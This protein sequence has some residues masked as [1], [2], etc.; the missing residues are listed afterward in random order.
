MESSSTLDSNKRRRL[1]PCLQSDDLSAS[2]PSLTGASAAAAPAAAAA[3]SAAA[4]A[5]ASAASAAAAAASAAA[6]PS[7]TGACDETS[8]ETDKDEE[9]PH[10]AHRG[11][12]SST[13]A[14]AHE[15]V[16]AA[17]M[18]GAIPLTN[19]EAV[20]LTPKDQQR[21][22]LPN[23]PPCKLTHF[24]HSAHPLELFAVHPDHPITCMLCSSCV[25]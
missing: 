5:A 22:G 12:E 8:M 11:F 20:R 19:M 15:E 13:V 23:E 24:S 4:A 18:A 21:A 14:E 10:V 6:A 7:L 17:L 3:A 1:D 25:R 9:S 16:L 2:A